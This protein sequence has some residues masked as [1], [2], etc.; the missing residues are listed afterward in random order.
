VGSF[1][2]DLLDARTRARLSG[3]VTGN[4]PSAQTMLI[5]IVPT[6]WAGMLRGQPANM[7]LDGCRI[8]QHC[9]ALPGIRSGQPSRPRPLPGGQTRTCTLAVPA[10]ARWARRPPQSSWAPS[11]RGRVLE[12]GLSRHPPTS[13]APGASILMSLG[14]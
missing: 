14:N 2:A 8:L 5:T 13:A 11:H 10:I 4:A 3:M 9:Y 7:C 1:S 12:P 6:L